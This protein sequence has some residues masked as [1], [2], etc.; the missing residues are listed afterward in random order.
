MLTN[1]VIL[2]SWLLSRIPFWHVPTLIERTSKSLHAYAHTLVNERQTA[3]LSGLSLESQAEKMQLRRPDILSSLVQANELSAPQLADQVLTMMAAGH[4]TT[5]STL[6]FVSVLLATH[7]D[8]Q[9]ALRAEIRA[10]TPSP[11]SDE[12][13][14]AAQLDKLPLLAAVC[15]ETLR[16][17][18]TVPFSARTVATPTRLG[19]RLVP[20]GTEIWLPI[21]AVNRATALWGPDADEFR[22]ERWIT[23]GAFNN[24]GGAASNFATMTFSQGPRSCLGMGYVS[25]SLSWDGKDD[26]ADVFWPDSQKLSYAV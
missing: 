19:G 6:A 20:P 17:F 7:P 1:L 5:S 25:F 9:S 24:N 10:N 2:P 23:D 16:M 3:L 13:V 4:E 15:A 12:T 22:P 26:N 14:S 11:A 21:W 8:T 18:P